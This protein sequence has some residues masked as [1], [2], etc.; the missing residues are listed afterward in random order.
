MSHLCSM[1]LMISAIQRVREVHAT[2]TAVAAA[3]AAALAA[4]AA[5]EQQQQHRERHVSLCSLM[6]SFKHLG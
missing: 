6:H 5:A 4:A 2:I 1:F 3:V